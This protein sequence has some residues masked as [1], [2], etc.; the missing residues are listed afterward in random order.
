LIVCEVPEERLNIPET[1]NS[2][3]VVVKAGVGI[4]VYI[5]VVGLA[6]SI[7]RPTSKPQLVAS[8]FRQPIVIT[9]LYHTVFAFDAI[10]K[11]SVPL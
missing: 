2:R 10:V 5:S 4:A 7:D 11:V 9:K 8:S 3:S 1:D 6:P